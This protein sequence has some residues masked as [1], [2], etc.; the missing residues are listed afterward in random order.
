MNFFAM[1]DYLMCI[2]TNSYSSYIMLSFWL[3]D[4]RTGIDCVSVS[5]HL[6][7]DGSWSINETTFFAGEEDLRAGAFHRFTVS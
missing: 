6:R 1:L 3:E 4:D 7:R 2:E 5:L